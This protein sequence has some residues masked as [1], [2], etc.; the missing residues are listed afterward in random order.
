MAL[1]TDANSRLRELTA[2]DGAL[3]TGI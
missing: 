1:G 2:D 3:A